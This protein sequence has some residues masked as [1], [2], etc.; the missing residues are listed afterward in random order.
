MQDVLLYVN[1]HSHCVFGDYHGLDP[2]VLT[3]LDALGMV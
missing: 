2:V 3:Q 1:I